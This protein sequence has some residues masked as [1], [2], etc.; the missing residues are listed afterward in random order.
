MSPLF[1]FQLRRV[2]RN[3]QFLFFT[4]LLPAL[5]TIFFTEIF[6]AQGLSAD[7]ESTGKPSHPR[8][9]HRS[10]HGEGRPGDGPARRLVTKL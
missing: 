8:R 6:G 10:D 5:F 3:R 2:A 7:R 9:T 1:V 4:V